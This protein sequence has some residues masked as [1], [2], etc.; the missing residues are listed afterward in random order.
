MDYV[1]CG[2]QMMQV[3]KRYVYDNGEMKAQITHVCHHCGNLAI[4]D[5]TGEVTWIDK[6]EKPIH[7]THD[8]QHPYMK[9]G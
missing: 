9:G 4:T 8:K 2:R 7:A 5:T 3:C 6:D 1:C